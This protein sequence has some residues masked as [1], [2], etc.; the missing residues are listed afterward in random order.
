MYASGVSFTREE[1]LADAEDSID[2]TEYVVFVAER[3][4]SVV[5]SSV[6]CALTVSSAHNGPARPDDAG[7][8]GLR[9]RP[10]RGERYRG[11]SLCR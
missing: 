5:A 1:A 4:V 6:G 9:R 10:A 7:F 11:W 3:E 2:S 8:S